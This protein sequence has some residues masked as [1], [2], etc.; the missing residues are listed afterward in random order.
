M[1]H[2]LDFFV[3]HGYMLLFAMVLAEQLGAPIPAIPVLL[4][5]GALKRTGERSAE[6]KRMRV[7]PDA[8]GRG[9]GRQ[10]LVALFRFVVSTWPARL[11][12]I[13]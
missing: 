6:V 4:A 1:P 8:Q 10:V 13:P 7:H 12:S 9:Y 5:M 11:P 2:T 3:R